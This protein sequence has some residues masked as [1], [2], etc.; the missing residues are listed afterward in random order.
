MK[1]ISNMLLI[2][3]FLTITQS[4]DCQQQS[5]NTPQEL[6][7]LIML[8]SYITPALQLAVLSY[9]EDPSIVT[10]DTKTGML[11]GIQ[12][13]QNILQAINKQLTQPKQPLTSTHKQ[14]LQQG[15]QAMLEATEIANM[16][17]AIKTSYKDPLILPIQKQ[18][19]AILEDQKQ[20]I[21]TM[22]SK[23]NIQKNIVADVPPLTKQA[24]SPHQISTAFLRE[25]IKQN[26]YTTISN[27]VQAANLLF[28]Q[29]CIALQLHK[30]HR[31]PLNFNGPISAT[32][33]VYTN[34]P[35]IYNAQSQ[36]YPVCEQLIKIGGS[37][38][39]QSLLEIRQAI[40]MSIYIANKKSA[41]NIGNML[42]ASI[43]S[44]IDPLVG[45]LLKC[46]AH[47][48]TLCLNPLYGATST[49][50]AQAQAW[51]TITKIA[52]GAVTAAVAIGTVHAY[53]PQIF[54]NLA[55]HTTEL[56]NWLGGQPTKAEQARQAEAVRLA[57]EQH[58]AEV[59]RLE[60]EKSRL[61]QEKRIAQEQAH[62]AEQQ[63]L[64]K[65]KAHA[66]QVARL[67]QEKAQLEAKNTADFYTNVGIGLG[68]ALIGG[69]AV[70]LNESEKHEKLIK[71]AEKTKNALLQEKEKLNSNLTN[72][73]NSAKKNLQEFSEN[74]NELTVQNKEY[75]LANQAQS[76]I[77]KTEYEFTNQKKLNTSK[78]DI[79]NIQITCDKQG[80]PTINAIKEL[81]KKDFPSLKHNELIITIINNGGIS[82]KIYC[83]S[84]NNT[85]IFFLKIS[86]NFYQEAIQ[87]KLQ[88]IQTSHIVRTSIIKKYDKF[89]SRDIYNKLPIIVLMEKFY[90]YTKPSGSQCIMELMH[91]AKGQQISYILKHENL[92]SQAK[93]MDAV[94]TTLGALQQVFMNYNDSDN[95][96]DWRTVAHNDFHT[97]NI[98][99]DTT[100]DRVY[101]I[102]N[103]RMNDNQSIKTDW[104][105]MLKTLNM[106]YDVTN[107]N[108]LKGSFLRGYLNSF[109]E[110]ER[111]PLIT[112]YFSIT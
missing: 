104:E 42:P 66:A 86:T 110:R 12:P 36:I 70:A 102:D 43:T 13:V 39:H 72:E 74:I 67:Q 101:L 95:P 3:A 112:K 23:I 44:Y 89:F 18:L 69:T 1:Y 106:L 45:Q 30:A 65:E 75:E 81:M 64:A 77:S 56:V 79:E 83:M 16:N 40:Q 47:L 53:N 26:D 54:N 107:A 84:I 51:S 85:P 91:A 15:L 62:L 82:E 103:E 61:A 55:E 41:I 49:D 88:T 9:L 20:T 27:P 59:T 93:C 109:P 25:I 90:V 32:N 108:I 94:G 60:Q 111:G 19:I 38:L 46:D 21:Q 31:I 2:A 24:T 22:L 76:N 11:Q 98:F 14:Q 96:D 10:F 78:I 63:K 33:Y 80:Y 87:K 97:A 52:I 17:I 35:A 50:I 8:E 99:Y 5:H 68:G 37:H 100:K 71:A 29:C 7:N 105:E 92:Q 58:Q 28:A 57:T 6:V 73:L 48:N 34:F 4:I